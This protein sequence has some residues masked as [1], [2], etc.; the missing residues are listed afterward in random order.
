MRQLPIR[1]VGEANDP[2]KLLTRRRSPAELARLLSAPGE[3][4]S[5]QTVRSHVQAGAPTDR[6]G[7]LTLAGYTAWLIDRLAGGP[8][9]PG[10]ASPPRNAERSPGVK[11]P[12]QKEVTAR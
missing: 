9:T 6:R 4:V 3:R 10:A 2:E 12:A 7:R 8:L 1:S 11:G 5:V